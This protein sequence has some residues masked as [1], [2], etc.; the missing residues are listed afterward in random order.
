MG[1]KPQKQ[2]ILAC[3]IFVFS[4]LC[5]VIL[6]SLSRLH[7]SINPEIYFSRLGLCLFLQFLCI[8][9]CWVCFSLPG[10]LTAA[11]LSSILVL[12]VC[13]VGKTGVFMWFLAEYFLFCFLLLRLD[14]FYANQIA[15]LRVNLEKI[16][17][18]K[19][20]LENSFKIKGEGISI[21]F[22][23]YS[24]YYNLRKLAED[25]AA[26]LSVVEICR[27][28]VQ[29][30][31]EFIPKGD[32]IYITLVDSQEQNLSLLAHRNLKDIEKNEDEWR[33]DLFDHWALKNRKRLIV[34]NVLQD[35][36]FDSQEASRNPGAMSL[37][38]APLL[39]DSR[40]IGLI[41]LQSD[42]KELF[43]NDDLR[44]LDTIANLVSFALSNALLYE[45]TQDLA[46]RDSLTGIYVRRY[47][48]ERL[49]EEHRRALMTNRPLS[50]LM[51]DLD[52]FKSCNDRYGHSV[53][54]LMLQKF[55]QII[56]EAA[57][58][59]IVGRYGGE[60]FIVLLPE[61][62]LE[63]AAQ[64]AESIRE[65]FES[66]ALLI[67]R[68]RIQMT[69]S[70]GVASMPDDAL[71]HEQLIQKAD[72]RLYYAKQTGRNKVCLKNS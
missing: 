9:G 11:A 39:D 6:Q 2:A 27:C 37:I 4:F 15:G 23:K 3:S 50:V 17:N 21:F 19:N 68:E 36:R 33:P 18:Q 41:R 45:Q 67:R 71:D 20:D 53:G 22:E 56:K 42:R 72:E 55:S 30:I 47:F 70:I 54:D 61:T 5:V 59:G 25:L 24:V 43:T 49:K 32:A 28:T 60:E 52:F 26:T 1:F 44:V 65:Q 29:R 38:M 16:N 35:F 13:W 40:L 51:C 64:V 62:K 7:G 63:E 57:G 58:S 31:Q 34:Q 12:F 66:S 48:F 8:L 10:G 14:Q 69:V 46:I